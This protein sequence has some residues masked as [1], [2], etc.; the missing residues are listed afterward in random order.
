MHAQ[1]KISQA[2]LAKILARDREWIEIVLFQVSAEFTT[3]FLVFAPEKS[4]YQKEQRHNDRC[5]NIDTELA[6]H[7]SGHT[8]N[9]FPAALA[10]DLQPMH[11]RNTVL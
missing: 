5:D 10:T 7:R 2:E 4:C 8:T 6:L 11:V 1:A 9:I 3:L